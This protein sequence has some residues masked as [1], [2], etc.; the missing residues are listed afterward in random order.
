MVNPD[1]NRY[2]L[3]KKIWKNSGQPVRSD[4]RVAELYNI[5]INCENYIPIP[6]LT[7]RGQCAI[8]TCLLSKDSDRMNKLRWATTKCPLP[9]PKWVEEEGFEQKIEPE[10]ETPGPKISRQSDCGCGK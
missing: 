5:C 3:E 4:E 6:L 9:E 8:C 7:D 2:R 10:V 1:L